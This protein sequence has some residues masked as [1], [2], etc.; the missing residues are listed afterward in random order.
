M[1][2]ELAR[3][4]QVL[5]SFFKRLEA[6]EAILRVIVS[7]ARIRAL[8]TFRGDPERKI[9]LDFSNRPARVV[10]D[11][12]T[13]DVDI[14]VTI[15]G[16]VMHEILSG[17]MSA[18][19]A[20]GQRELLLRGS[21]SHL[22]RLIPLFDFGPVLY[23]EHMAKLDFRGFSPR[24][25]SETSEEEFM[26]SKSFKGDPIPLVRL[27]SFEKV[28]FGA[29]N[30]ISYALGY[31][32]GIVRYRVFKKLNL[33]DVLSAM[34]RGLAAAAPPERLGSSSPRN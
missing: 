11:D 3:P 20:L 15:R 18:G 24:S 22:A 23:R 26:G 31:F 17:R 28:V 29:L 19:Q 32:V 7:E 2:P 14:S 1:R 10:F 16:E 33:F 5:A 4:T 12:Q 30:G 25:N 34:S 6:M 27:S 21:A 9:L 13:R 8:L